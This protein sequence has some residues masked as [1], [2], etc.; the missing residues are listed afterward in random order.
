MRL[1]HAQAVRNTL[2]PAKQH[3]AQVTNSILDLSM[4]PTKPID[5]NPTPD[6]VITYEYWCWH[7]Y[8]GWIGDDG[9]C[10]DS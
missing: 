2:Q 8:G 10:H 9:D 1:G 4:M 6:P 5:P 3:H 7:V